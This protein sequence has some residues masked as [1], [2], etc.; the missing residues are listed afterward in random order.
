LTIAI[1]R[2]DFEMVSGMLKGIVQRKMVVLCAFVVSTFA[3]TAVF[4]ER[5][6]ADQTPAQAT[7]EATNQA[8][9]TARS[10]EQIIDLIIA[11]EHQ[12]ISIIRRYKPIIETYIQDVSPDRKEEAVPVHDH[13]FLGQA[14][15]SKGVVDRTMIDKNK[16]KHDAISPVSHLSGMFGS[17]YVPEGFLQMVYIDTN[18]FDRRH[19]RFN[20]ASDAV[21]GEVHCLVFDIGPLPNSGNNRF[22]GRIWV[23]D[24]DYTIVR[25]NGFYVPAPGTN[26]FNLHFDSWRV[27]V[28]SGLWLPAYIFTKDINLKVAQGKE[29]SFMSQTRLWG[30][31]LKDAGRLEEFSELRIDSG[32]DIED[33]ASHDRSPLESQREWRHQAEI[34]VLDALQRTG[35]I[36]PRGEA[37]NFLE[38]VANKLIAA[39]DLTFNPDVHCRV[40][41]TTTLEMFTVGH[42]IVLS[43]GLLDVLPD[44]ASLAM[45]LAQE[46]GDIMVSQATLDQWGFSDA[47]SVTVAD[48]LDQFSFKDTPEHVRLASQKALEFL[49]N[50][51]YK[52]NLGSAGL[53]LKQLDADSKAL[54]SLINSH[55]GNRVYLAGQLMSLASNIDAKNGQAPALPIGLRVVL[56]PWNDEVQLMKDRASVLSSSSEKIPF[57]AISFMPYLTRYGSSVSRETS[58]TSGNPH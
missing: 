5:A 10:V 46:L 21:L 24:Q 54:P 37:D 43:R 17:S 39:N 6:R 16:K 33:Q 40:M 15:L 35:L 12:E 42:T 8:S 25:F 19:Y 3:G 32:N 57:E 58:G 48:A 38:T 30:Y 11:R 18:G 20:R 27:N 31:S 1:V 44:E 4:P 22:R 51:A 28:Q 14:D 7:S 52:D 41:L 50:S 2:S 55:L 53:F 34:N 23:E 26:G 56:N 47:T 49:K 29:V 45:M 13:Y 9:A 36:A